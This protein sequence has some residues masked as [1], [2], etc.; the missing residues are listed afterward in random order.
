MVSYYLESK[1]SNDSRYFGILYTI[2]TLF[3]FSNISISVSNIL[4]L[5]VIDIHDSSFFMKTI[6][7][8]LECC[9][10][11]LFINFL[12]PWKRGKNIRMLYTVIPH[13][14]SLKDLLKRDY[15]VAIKSFKFCAMF[16]MDYSLPYFCFMFMPT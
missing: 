2:K 11:L 5:L 3:Q 4:I 12:S 8:Q 6:I 13:W 7:F 15:C 14:H 10:Y 1:N 16:K 9:P